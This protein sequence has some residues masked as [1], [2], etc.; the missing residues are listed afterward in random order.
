MPNGCTNSKFRCLSSKTGIWPYSKSL[1][2]NSKSCPRNSKFHCSSS[3]TRI[4]LIR[5]LVRGIR[6]SIAHRPEP[7][8]YP[9]RNSVALSPRPLAASSTYPRT[10]A[11]RL[12]V[13]TALVSTLNSCGNKWARLLPQ[14]FLRRLLSGCCLRRLWYPL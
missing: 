13:K 3:R 5:K 10:A 6:N 14:R 2:I 1:S 7:G 12:L 9:V 11:L 4:L 8:F